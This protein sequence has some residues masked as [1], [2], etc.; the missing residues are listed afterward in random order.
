MPIHS[1]LIFL[2]LLNSLRKSA[3]NSGLAQRFLHL[4]TIDISGWIILFVGLSFASWGLYQ[5]LWPLLAKCQ[6]IL[7]LW[8]LKICSDIAKYPPRWSE[9]G[10]LW[11]G[12]TAL[13]SPLGPIDTI[14]LVHLR[15]FGFPADVRCGGAWSLQYVKGPVGPMLCSSRAVNL[16]AT[17]HVNPQS[18]GMLTIPACFLPLLLAHLFATFGQWWVLNLIDVNNA[19]NQ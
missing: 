17:I 2:L 11:L 18:A 15:L 14:S 5:H 13:G 8:Q 10:H 19:N 7:H 3:I 12:T 1:L 9:G 16:Q 6:C 4:S